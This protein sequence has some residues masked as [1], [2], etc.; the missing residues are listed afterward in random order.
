MDTFVASGSGGLTLPRP[1]TFGPDGD[2]YVGS[3]GTGDILRFDGTT[4]AFLNAFVPAGSGGLGGPTFLLFHDFAAVGTVPE[5]PT[6]V[7]VL[8]A[9]AF[10][11]FTLRRRRAA[12]SRR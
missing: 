10:C 6:F 9:L 7:L 3:F 2:L 12:P 5:P 11:L 4:G 8:T 1:L